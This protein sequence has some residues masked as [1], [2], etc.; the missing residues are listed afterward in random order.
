MAISEI[1]Y[2]GDK[3]TDK[4]ML[5]IGSD[6]KKLIQSVFPEPGI[7]TSLS[8]YMFEQVANHLR[9]IDIT[10]Y[11]KRAEKKM[12]IEDLKQLC[13]LVCAKK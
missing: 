6:D 11:T 13:N 4:T 3:P 2:G 9:D 5:R 7:I 12:S 8:V 1:F 10:T